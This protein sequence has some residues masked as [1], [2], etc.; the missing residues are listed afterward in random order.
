[1]QPSV[2]RVVTTLG[3]AALMDDNIITALLQQAVAQHKLAADDIVLEDVREV[4]MPSTVLPPS[5]RPAIHTGMYEALFTNSANAALPLQVFVPQTVVYRFG[6]PAAWYSTVRDPA[7]GR[8]VVQKRRTTA[9]KTTLILHKF[10]SEG[11]VDQDRDPR[12]AV[13]VSAAGPQGQSSTP[14]ERQRKPS[15]PRRR[16]DSCPATPFIAMFMS[17]TGEMRF[18]DEQQLKA[19]V[20]LAASE[21]RDGVLQQL[22]LPSEAGQHF[23]AIRVHWSPSVC[24]VDRRRNRFASRKATNG[25]RATADDY[26][27]METFD[28]PDFVGSEEH[29]VTSTRNLAVLSNQA[30]AMAA[31]FTA[32]TSGQYVID[33]MAITVRLTASAEV[34]LLWADCVRV[35]EVIPVARNAAAALPPPPVLMSSS[36]KS[37]QPHRSTPGLTASPDTPGALDPDVDGESGLSAIRQLSRSRLRHVTAVGEYIARR[38][39]YAATDTAKPPVGAAAAT[40][41]ADVPST[42]SGVPTRRGLDELHFTLR[43]LYTYKVSDATTSLRQPPVGAGYVRCGYCGARDVPKKDAASV[44]YSAL[45]E[46]SRWAPSVPVTQPRRK[47][48]EF[49]PASFVPFEDEIPA[50]CR[51]PGDRPRSYYVSDAGP[52]EPLPGEVEGLPSFL[53][54]LHP[55]MTRAHLEAYHDQ[56]AFRRTTVTLCVGCVMKLTEGLAL[57]TESRLCDAFGCHFDKVQAAPVPALAPMIVTSKLQSAIDRPMSRLLAASSPLPLAQRS[58]VSKSIEKRKGTSQRALSNRL[59][60]H[61]PLLSRPQSQALVQRIRTET[62]LMGNTTPTCASKLGAGFEPVPADDAES[63]DW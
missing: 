16:T 57:K 1:M 13:P 21:D 56:P 39:R 3:A 53:R 9:L 42:S 46:A 17:I 58:P 33:S 34:V 48:P 50:W 19:F 22:V 27:H 10:L 52:D 59:S 45:L 40:G 29:P 47:L 51:R 25:R 23:D 36:Q 63:I 43:P 5:D 38:L 14:S 35:S 55:L 18:F 62:R 11:F 7:T 31:H 2:P 60:M 44:P 12:L 61:S 32:V 41:Q 24:C 6:R 26:V 49:T 4:R 28:G 15:P 30:A 8:F 37:R 54:H 20:L